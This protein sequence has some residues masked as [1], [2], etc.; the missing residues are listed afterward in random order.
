MWNNVCL[1]D[2]LAQ[3]QATETRLAFPEVRVSRDGDKKRAN[4][5]QDKEKEMRLVP[6]PYGAPIPDVTREPYVPT[7]CTTTLPAEGSDRL[8]TGS[9]VGGES[10]SDLVAEAEDRVRASDPL[11]A[12][13]GDGKGEP[14]TP[15]KF[16]DRPKLNEVLEE[17]GKKYGRFRDNAW[18]AQSLKTVI[19]GG[20]SYDALEVDHA[21]ALDMIAAK[22]SR[23]VTGDPDYPDNWDDIA[24]FATLV[25]ERLRS[26]K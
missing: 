12:G 1:S 11:M 8:D 22:I 3:T 6:R 23:I 13:M 20:M 25:A 17:R 9:V 2:R 19:R 15:E 24:G 4:T 18:I 26:D 7:V 5:S 16:V 10:V 14:W 21:E